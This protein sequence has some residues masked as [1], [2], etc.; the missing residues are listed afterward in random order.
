MRSSWFKL[1][2]LYEIYG[3]F[4]YVYDCYSVLE[5]AN[6]ASPEELR[7][8]YYNLAETRHPDKSAANEV[9]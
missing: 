4:E 2:R 7:K 9:L 1:E 5:V 8:S 6:D 3:F